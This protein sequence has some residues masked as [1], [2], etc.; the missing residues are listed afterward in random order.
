MEG[1]TGFWWGGNQI[2]EV[3]CGISVK[4]CISWQKITFSLTFSGNR[5]KFW[6]FTPIYLWGDFGIRAGGIV[7]VCG[8][9]IPTQKM[10]N[11]AT[12]LMLNHLMYDLLK[13]NEW[14]NRAS[15][16]IFLILCLSFLILLSLLSK[17]PYTVWPSHIWKELKAIGGVKGQKICFDLIW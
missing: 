8:G 3:G 15:S 17:R 11:L 16:R 7:L 12:K 5:R 1:E 13:I 2:L 14:I 4:K 9:I 10:T 6:R